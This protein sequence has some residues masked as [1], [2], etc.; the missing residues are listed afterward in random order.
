MK[1]IDILIYFILMIV[2]V[3]GSYFSL[4]ISKNNLPIIYAS[5]SGILTTI[6]WCYILHY[7]K[8]NVV[9][10]SGSFDAFSTLG[11]FL[12]FIILGQQLT[13]HQILGGSLIITGIFLINK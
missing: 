3:I 5:I 10:I 9:N 1:S 6:L 13:I 11:Y 12:G 4:Q 8:N 7:S 2:G